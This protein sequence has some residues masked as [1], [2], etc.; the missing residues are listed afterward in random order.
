MT[1][2][3]FD[4]PPITLLPP[5]F[6]P[7]KELIISD[8]SSNQTNYSTYKNPMADAKFLH[9]IATVIE[10]SILDE[11]HK[12]PSWSLLIDESNTITHDKTCAVVSKHMAG[13]IPI[14]HYLGLIELLETDASAIIRN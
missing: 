10:E 8:N 1:E 7:K 9:A 13:N 11:V 2:L 4:Q 3:V 12:S 14:L 6:S 5:S